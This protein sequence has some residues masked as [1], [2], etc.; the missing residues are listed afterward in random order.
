MG[1]RRP[2][3]RTSRCGALADGLLAF[4]DALGLDE[5][6]LVANDTGGA[7]A[8]IFAARHPDR[9]R[10]FTLT[11]CEAHDNVPPEA[12]KPTVDLAR[13]GALAPGAPALLADLAV[14]RDV[15]FAMGYEDA[16]FLTPEVV[17]GSW[18]R[19]SVRRS[20]RGNFERFLVVRSIPPIC[21]RSNPR[22]AN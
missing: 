18:S 21:S 13:A 22:C 11:N 19:C 7:V 10:T 5:I 3:I 4:C 20:G 15:V 14:A 16:E 1:A 6:D 2:R 8:Q 9:L 17:G 12:F